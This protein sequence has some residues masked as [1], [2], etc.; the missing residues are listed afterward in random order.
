MKTLNKKNGVLVALLVFGMMFS[1]LSVKAY[2][3]DGGTLGSTT[4]SYSIDI[5]G[6]SSSY[7]Q[8][9]L[10]IA[11]KNKVEKL[12]IKNINIVKKDGGGVTGGSVSKKDAYKAEY[13]GAA[14][15][16]GSIKSISAHFYVTSANFGS[17]SKNASY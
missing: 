16:P 10:N 6:G 14:Y 1:T 9:Y 5:R 12:G 17:F 3:T 4:V 15:G 2:S 7:S 13:Y 11:T 8:A